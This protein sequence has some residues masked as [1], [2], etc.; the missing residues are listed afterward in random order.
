MPRKKE[1]EGWQYYPISRHFTLHKRGAAA[2]RSVLDSG[3][4]IAIGVRDQT[5][6]FILVSTVLMSSVLPSSSDEYST[7]E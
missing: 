3:T 2:Q 7:R 5:S 6:M 4:H 1:L